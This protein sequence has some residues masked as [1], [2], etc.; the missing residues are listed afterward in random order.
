M[1]IISVPAGTVV[2][3]LDATSG[4]EG[5]ALAWAVAEAT[6]T[7]CDLTLVHAV[8]P[9]GDGWG[10]LGPAEP[11]M[12]R[13]EHLAE[14]QAALA[15]ARA[16]VAALAPTLRVREVLRL[17]GPRCAL[18]DLAASAAVV[19]LGGRESV[20]GTTRQSSTARY[21]IAQAPCPVVVLPAR[22]VRRGRIS[23]AG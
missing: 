16:E 15:A 21:L 6:R 14:G 9:D 12:V 20:P 8:G 19:V 18:M 11:G 22:A 23:L 17:A 2:V 10:G 4:A 3:A 13:D 7:G 5:E 1:R